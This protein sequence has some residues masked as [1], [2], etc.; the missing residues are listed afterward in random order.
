MASPKIQLI[1]DFG[2]GLGAFSTS[3]TQPMEG[4]ARPD[5]DGSLA[6]IA[7]GLVLAIIVARQEGA[8]E[9]NTPRLVCPEAVSAIAVSNCVR[10]DLSSG[11]IQDLTTGRQFQAA[12]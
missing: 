11:Q 12:R 5:D 3:A 2:C 9:G 7:D 6:V 4:I 1:R 8:G 10:L